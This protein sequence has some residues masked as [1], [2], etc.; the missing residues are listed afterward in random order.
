MALLGT[1]ITQII[2]LMLIGTIV[3]LLLPNN[4]MR[5]YVNLVSGLLL[6]LIL[7]QPILYLFSVDMTKMVHQVEDTLFDTDSSLQMSEKKMKTQK[8][9][10]ESMQEAYIWNEISSQL[11]QSANEVLEEKYEL[12]VTGIEVEAN[13]DETDI[14]NILTTIAPKSKQN[15]NEGHDIGISPV[16]IDAKETKTEAVDEE[17]GQVIREELAKVWDVDPS[18]I[19]LLREGQID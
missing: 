1:W 7:T 18:Q 19:Q 14:E 4:R 2:V 6:L 17:K 8:Q 9:D 15:K 5:K 3:E 11:T 16:E 12:T 13:E 10:I